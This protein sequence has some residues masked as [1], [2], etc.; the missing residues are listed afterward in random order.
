MEKES[1]GFSKSGH[2]KYKNEHWKGVNAI[3]KTIQNKSADRYITK[4]GNSI[5]DISCPNQVL[6]NIGVPVTRLQSQTVCTPNGVGND[7]PSL[8]RIKNQEKR[9]DLKVLPDFGVL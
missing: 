4:F 2:W 1:I 3:R 5:Y 6:Q 8:Y 9:A 7:A